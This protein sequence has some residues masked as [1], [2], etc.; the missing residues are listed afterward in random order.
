MNVEQEGDIVAPFVITKTNRPR[1][2][3][4]TNHNV[5]VM[6]HMA[7]ADEVSYAAVEDHLHHYLVS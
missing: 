6:I 3:F 5:A 7:K 4:H 1:V 2:V